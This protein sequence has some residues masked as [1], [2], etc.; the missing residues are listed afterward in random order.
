M[1]T[2]PLFSGKGGNN[3]IICDDFLGDPSDQLVNGDLVTFTDD[4]NVTQH[5]IVLFSTQPFGYGPTR[6]PGYIYFTTPFLNNVTGKRVERIRVKSFGKAS[7]NLIY[8]L[9]ENVV[10]SLES[11]PQDTGISYQVYKEFVTDEIKAGETS[12]RITTNK[13]NEKFISDPFKTTIVLAKVTDRDEFNVTSFE[14]RF[15]ALNETNAISVALS[16][17][18]VTYTFRSS[19]LVDCVLKIIAPIEVTNAQAKRKNLIQDYQQSFPFDP[20]N[21]RNAELS[22]LSS[23]AAALEKC[24][25]FRLKSLMLTDGD[26]K[27]IDIKDNY[28]FD[29]GQRDGYYGLGQL[30]LKEGRPRPTGN[31]IATYDYFQH[32]GAGDF[33]SVDSYLHDRGVSY[34]LIPVYRPI[35]VVPEANTDLSD[36]SIKLRDCVDFRPILNVAPPN[37]S[38][39]P[40][41]KPT[42]SVSGCL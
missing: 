14:G 39:L 10:S 3:Y 25:I 40:I 5:L 20:Q 21:P 9:P 29:N 16:G 19:L 22:P 12:V 23:Q 11:D 15:I 37:P 36:I 32:E 35:G 24:D 17:T 30:I 38:V 6:V 28:L 7:E 33:F 42:R 13:P 4:Q 41:T 1:L 18:E 31:V 8:Q 34:G 2:D 26:G 27:Q